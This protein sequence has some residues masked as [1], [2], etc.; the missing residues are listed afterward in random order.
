MRRKEY[1][2]ELVKLFE[3]V[4]DEE[5]APASQD[6]N[7]VD[8]GKN[9]DGNAADQ[10]GKPA[11]SGESDAANSDLGDA[12]Y[13]STDGEEQ[14]I[15]PPIGDT[16]GVPEPKKMAKLFGL[17]KD[18]LSYSEIFHESLTNIDMNLLSGEKVESIKKNID[19]IDDVID[20]VRTYIIDTFPTDKYEK[21]LYIYILLRTE[22][23]TIIKLLRESL[24]LNVVSD[25]QK[26]Q[27]PQKSDEKR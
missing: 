11:A 24:E 18:L 6:Q 8:S 25:E 26:D 23:M 1:F 5:V 4:S 17:F 9:V 3:E 16:A 2:K 22:L 19:R 12:D 7:N 14:K 15:L 20:K 27:K 13:L 10:T 21:A